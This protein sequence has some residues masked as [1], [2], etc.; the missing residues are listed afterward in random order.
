MPL[1][2]TRRRPAFALE[3]LALG[4]KAHPDGYHDARLESVELNERLP[5]E[6][7]ADSVISVEG[8]G[9]GRRFVIVE[10]Q[11]AWDDRKVWSWA[12]YVGGLMGRHRCAVLLVV[13]CLNKAVAARY[14]RPIM[15]TDSCMLLCPVV[16]G[17]DQLP[18]PRTTEDVLASPELAVLCAIAHSDDFDVVST[19]GTAMAEIED[20]RGP[21]YY[22]YLYGH[23]A[24]P[25]RA[26]LEEIMSTVTPETESGI[27]RL[28]R[29]REAIAEARTK[30]RTEVHTKAE[31]LVLVL[32]TRGLTPS[33]SQRER[34]A[35]CTDPEALT[36]W[37]TRAATATATAEVFGDD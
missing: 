12:A 9:G 34:I 22:D 15:P 7:M 26:R 30:A 3:L 20:E 24:E 29:R 8:P 23:L 16:V 4:L 37:V 6:Y 11:R 17:P 28:M 27:E 32:E 21:V 31:M 14:D 1:E 19:V 13:V 25:V 18:L 5:A 35:S 36:A 2:M 10:V 33:P